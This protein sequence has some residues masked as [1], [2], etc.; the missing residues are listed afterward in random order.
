MKSMKRLAA[1]ILAGAV[2]TMTFTACGAPAPA[3]EPAQ[4]AA[5]AAEET[6]ET[7]Q[8]EKVDLANATGRLKT[9]L[10]K[11]VI[12]VTTEPY[13]PPNEFIDPSK[14]GQD[15]YVGSDM[16]LAKLIAERLGVKLEI[17]PLEFGPTISSVVEGKYDLAISALAYTPERAEALELSNG[18]HFTDASKNYG[19]LIRTEDKD[20]IKGPEDLADRTI[21][22]QSGSIQEALVLD[23]IP[24]YKEF[25]RVSSMSPDA[26][27]SVQEGKADA[28]A[29]A[30]TNA[31][32]YVDNNPDCGMMVVDSWY[33]TIDEKFGGTRCG[34]PK[35]ET[36][37]INFVNEIIAE[38]NESGQYDKWYDEYAEYAASLGL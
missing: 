31:Q 36:D 7:A 15:Q 11:G 8:P 24:K 22:T 37:L 30:T 23:Q 20:N 17:I 13:F 6:Q 16:E 34:A 28:A 10:E 27:L 35:G 4:S 9:I 25:K 38:L 1:M 12:Q 32:L 29:V 3:A 5:P 21:V 33:F 14:T 2:M 19:L 18:Y 26:F